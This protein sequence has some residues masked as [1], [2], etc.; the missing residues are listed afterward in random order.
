MTE[1]H[2][3]SPEDPAVI[4]AARSGDRVALTV[5]FEGYKGMLA[6]WILR[7]TGDVAS[8][9]DL[10]QEVFVAAFRALPRF[11]GEAKIRSWLREIATN[12]VRNWWDSKR[13]RQLRESKAADWLSADAVDPPDA[14]LEAKQQR[15]R[16]YRA[17]GDLP[18]NL[19][20]AFVVR[21]LEGM[22]LRE[23][24]AFLRVPVS[25]VSWRTRRAEAMLCESL[26]L[27]PP[28]GK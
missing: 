14:D 15:E 10:V 28:P 17:L 4:A 13:R 25:T 1:P 6:R 11:R 24:S 23:A 2:T 12:H 26:G 20:E 7:M 18:H 9:D 22:D 8:V 5:I 19:R 27:P 3:K 21:A 16:F